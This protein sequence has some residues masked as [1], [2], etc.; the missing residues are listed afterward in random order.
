MRPIAEAV[1]WLMLDDNTEGRQAGQ[2]RHGRRLV[3]LGAQLAKADGTM[4]D[5]NHARAWL[6]HS[7][8]AGERADVMMTVP[9]DCEADRW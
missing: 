6:P 9:V 4:L 3:R 8:A 5:Q 7:I 2:D 1:R